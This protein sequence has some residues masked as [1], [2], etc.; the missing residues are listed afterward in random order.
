[1]LFSHLVRERNPKYWEHKFIPAR[2]EYLERETVTLFQRALPNSSVYPKMIYNLSG[3]NKRPE[4]DIVVVC[5]DVLLIVECKAG[6]LV[7]ATRRGGRSSV[8]RDL[9]KT[10]VGAQEQAA[11]L[12]NE[13]VA[14]KEVVLQSQ[15]DGKS[16][17]IRADDF[18]TVIRVSV[19]ME[20]ISSVSASLWT[21][22]SAGLL[23]ETVGCWS[24]S[25]NDLRVIVEL[26]DQPALF[27]HY[28][29]RRVDL[30]CLNRIS[31]RDEL[32]LLMHYIERG[33][34]FREQNEPKEN[35]EIMITSWTQR[36]EQYYRRMDGIAQSGK[37]PVLKL[38]RRTK[39]LLDSLEMIRPKNY[40]SAS[41][42][43][44]DFD[45]PAREGLLGKLNE[46]L[47]RIRRGYMYAVSVLASSGSKQGVLLATSPV[48]ATVRDAM[49]ARAV[50][51]CKT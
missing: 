38:G 5:D 4:V 13:L 14:K 1:M 37:K 48:P 28:L 47:S 17:V 3:Q 39:Q 16:V 32:D 45:I 10:I 41:V 50:E 21:L 24:V 26:L 35:Q 31:S 6:A 18:R 20:L 33:L 12:V 7:N 2:D 27:L 19:T 49:Q 30:N 29:T 36:L 46:H 34:F 11:R 8:V 44:L 9:K 43:I 51:M 42:A 25:L 15:V 22:K 23:K 40:L